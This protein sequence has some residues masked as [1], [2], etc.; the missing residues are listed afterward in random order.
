MTTEYRFFKNHRPKGRI[1]CSL[2]NRLIIT[3]NIL[4]KPIDKSIM[5]W[6]TPTTIRLLITKK[7][8][9]ELLNK[10]ELEKVIDSV[11]KATFI[12]LSNVYKNHKENTKTSQKMIF[13]IM[14]IIFYIISFS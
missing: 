12:R 11:I 4:E 14:S 8:V 7:E 9:A 5:M 2:K 1:F 6:Y 13:L 10:K 3:K